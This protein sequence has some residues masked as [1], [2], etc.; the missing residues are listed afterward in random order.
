MI[1][2]YVRLRETAVLNRPRQRIAVTGN[3][4]AVD[5]PAGHILT[6]R[7][8]CRKGERLAAAC[9]CA[10]LS[11][12]GDVIAGGDVILD[13]LELRRNVNRVCTE[14]C[15]RDSLSVGQGSEG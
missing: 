13:L 10:V 1:C 12:Y 7:R 3:C 9:S 11:V 15:I 14:M 2:R 8:Y 5:R 6:R 4:L